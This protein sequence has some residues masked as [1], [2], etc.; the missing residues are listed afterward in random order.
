[1]KKISGYITF[2]MKFY[3]FFV[4]VFVENVIIKRNFDI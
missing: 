2:L 3:N 1:M 4:L